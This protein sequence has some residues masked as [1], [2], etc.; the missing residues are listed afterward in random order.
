[1]N[2]RR[3]TSG[4]CST[5]LSEEEEAK[6]GAFSIFE[7]TKELGIMAKPIDYYHY[8][9]NLQNVKE[10]TERAKKRVRSQGIGVY[11]RV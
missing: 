7:H 9:L 11:C 5:S 10:N 3:N 8:I 6:E 1:M 4:E 2:V